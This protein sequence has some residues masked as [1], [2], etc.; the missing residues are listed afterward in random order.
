MMSKANLPACLILREMTNLDG[1][2][3]SQSG[4]AFQMAGRVWRSPPGF[5]EASFL[6]VRPP[7]DRAKATVV[8]RC[9]IPATHPGSGAN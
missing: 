5:W 4:G 8:L 6:I 7:D 3:R 1:T 2:R 9:I